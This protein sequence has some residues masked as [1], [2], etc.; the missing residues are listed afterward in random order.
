MHCEPERW[1]VIEV[2]RTEASPRLPPEIVEAQLRQASLLRSQAVA[3][4]FR[5]LVGSLRRRS[6]HP[7][8][9]LYAR[10]ATWPR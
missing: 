2:R 9:T 4:S 5:A 6:E 1:D 3:D 8:R 10:L 7:R